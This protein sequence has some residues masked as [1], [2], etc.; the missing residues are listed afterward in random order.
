MA[1][2][3]YSA[4]PVLPFPALT[5]V[6]LTF[7]ALTALMV[8]GAP[9]PL[10]AQGLFD[11]QRWRGPFDFLEPQQ[12]QQPQQQPERAPPPDYS[13]APPPRRADPRAEQAVTTPV[14]VLGDSMADWLG[15][16][17][18]LSYADAPEI[19]ILRRHKTNSGLIRSET[20]SDPRGE[21]PDWPAAARDLINAAKPKF[22]L[23]MIGIND[24]RQYRDVS[25]G[26]R[27]AAPKAPAAAQAASGPSPSGPSTSVPSPSVPSPS[28]PS[29]TGEATPGQVAGPDIAGR[30]VDAN[31]AADVRQE[32]LKQDEPRADPRP[33]PRADPK[34]EPPQGKPADRPREAAPPP[35]APSAPVVRNLEFRSDA[36]SEAYARRIDETIAALKTSGVPVF[37]VGL[38]PLRGSRSAADV[39]YLNDLYRGRADK[40]GIIFI[41]VSDGFVDD[42]GR[43]VQYGPD[44]EGQTRRLRTGDGVYFTTAGAKK[45]AHFVQRE[46]QRW[47]NNRAP[48]A[49]TVPDEPGEAKD[50][51]A[52]PG[53]QPTG[54]AHERPLSGPVVTL[55]G[56][57]AVELGELLGGAARQPK[58]DAMADKVLVQGVPLTAPAGRADDSSW[59]RRGVAPVGADPAVGVTDLPV[60]PMLAERPPGARSADAAPAQQARTVRRPR[61][62]S[63][64]DNSAGNQQGIYR[65]DYRRPQPPGQQQQP[66][67]F[68]SLFGGGGFL[69]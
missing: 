33:D 54:G 10:R 49:L 11:Q 38:P 41:D 22:V 35:A 14:L 3:A 63:L 21:Y 52:A 37:W 32:D 30:D 18:E 61:P 5:F 62:A 7:A 24:R 66:F 15:Y 48:V 17:L 31:A 59:P 26:P 64:V 45:L 19:G 67:T 27:A 12:P 4:V 58:G 68:P 36:W 65:P 16:G 56:E 40:A 13:R 34:P 50:A 44:V 60:T 47:V 53:T 29:A 51:K 25:G 55:A 2:G 20:R 23:M 6:A 9:A 28:G 46:I 42:D 69:R 8:A 1:R 57:R 39:A 43:Y